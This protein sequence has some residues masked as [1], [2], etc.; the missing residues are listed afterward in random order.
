MGARSDLKAC[1]AARVKDAARIAE[2]E[3][4]VAALKNPPPPPPPDPEPEPIT[5]TF[6]APWRPDALWS[7]PATGRALHPNSAAM[8]ADFIYRAGNRNSCLSWTNFGVPVVPARTDGKGYVIKSSTGWAVNTNDA[9]P[10]PIPDGVVLPSGSDKHLCIWD[11]QTHRAWDLN[12]AVYYP[13]S[14]TWTASSGS[15]Y[16]TDHRDGITPEKNEW[17]SKLAG[18]TSANFPLLGGLIRPEEIHAG[19]IEHALVFAT[20]VRGYYH[21]NPATH[22]GGNLTPNYGAITEG[23]HLKLDMSETEINALQ[24][25]AWNKTVLIALAEFGMLFRDGGGGFSIL[26]ENPVN[27]FTTYPSAIQGTTYP[28]LSVPWSRLRVLAVPGGA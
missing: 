14:D 7:Q 1:E 23:H 16:T 17:G 25:A 10:V 4:E 27:R 19:R 18:A 2:L 6:A 26:A 12:D 9:G 15:T 22:H 21:V 24:V 20:P 5:Q 28:V 3:A 8:I 13:D 11:A